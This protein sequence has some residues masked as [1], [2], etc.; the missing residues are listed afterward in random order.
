[1]EKNN[2]KIWFQNWWVG[3]GD[4]W[5]W[6]QGVEHPQTCQKLVDRQ[7]EI[8]Q[9]ILKNEYY[10]YALRLVD[11]IANQ[12]NIKMGRPVFRNRKV[13]CYNPETKQIYFSYEN[14]DYSVKNGFAEYATVGHVWWKNGYQPVSRPSYWKF[15]GGRQAVWMIVLHEMAHRTQH[16]KHGSF[17]GD[18][19][20]QIFLSELNELI[21][22]FPYDEVK[23]I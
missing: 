20:G 11:Y 12:M 13:S 23:N 22:L 5:S 14:V 10:A 1:M 2:A 3:W 7:E 4:G 15:Q 16:D 21:I 17:K 19:H 6:H 9:E 18:H 8:R